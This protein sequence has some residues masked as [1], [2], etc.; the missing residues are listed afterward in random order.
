LWLRVVPSAGRTVCFVAV[1]MRVSG[2]VLAFIAISATRNVVIDH[3]SVK[4]AG[5]IDHL[6]WSPA[7]PHRPA[8][9][10]VFTR[11]GVEA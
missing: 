6:T 5:V 3:L 11:V 8:L 7:R 10:V 9:D 2:Q 1:G 4:G